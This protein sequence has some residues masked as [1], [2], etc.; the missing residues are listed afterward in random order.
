MVDEICAELGSKQVI[1]KSVLS[2]EELRQMAREGV[3]I[4]AHTQT[5]PILTQ[6]PPERIRQEVAGSQQDLQ[7]EIGSVLPVFCYPNGDCNDTVVR[8]LQEEGFVT[9]Y[10]MQ[11]GQNNLG[12]VDALR[13]CRTSIT[14]RTSPL[15]F[16]LR[17]LTP[18]S[19]LDKWRHRKQSMKS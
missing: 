4:G 8:I 13:L 18:F 19:Y 10:T 17:L 5:H 11:D 14:R 6:L 2:W 16:Q 12:S 1:Q 9:A 7:R 15:I 3:T